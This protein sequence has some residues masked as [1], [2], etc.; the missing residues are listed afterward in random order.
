VVKGAPERLAIEAGEIDAI[1]DPGS[2]SAI[3][4]PAAQ[5]A[6]IERKAEFRSL[7]GL[8]FD[9]YPLGGT[10]GHGRRGLGRT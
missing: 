10:S 6:L 5:R 8:A 1:I 7:I 4:L 3:L 9:W 2:G